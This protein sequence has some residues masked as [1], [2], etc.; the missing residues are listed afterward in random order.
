MLRDLSTSKTS[1]NLPRPEEHSEKMAIRHR[2]IVKMPSKEAAACLPSTQ[3]SFPMGPS[4]RSERKPSSQSALTSSAKQSIRE[5]SVVAQLDE[6]RKMIFYVDSFDQ[7][8]DE[9]SVIDIPWTVLQ[10][11]SLSHEQPHIICEKA[12]DADSDDLMNELMKKQQQL[13]ALENE[14]EPRLRNLLGQVV[15]ERI[16]YDSK[17]SCKIRAIRDECLDRYNKV[18]ERKK[19]AVLAWQMQQ[20][21]DMDAV[22]DICN[23]GEVSVNNQILF[24]E[25]CNVA[26]HQVC[27]GIESVPVGD[28]FCR[29]C[30]FF[31]RH[32]IRRS[33]AESEGLVAKTLSEPLPI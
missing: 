12:I 9:I 22:C 27:Y 8:G 6:A 2:M 33:R 28:W 18:M 20:E 30:R 3:T 11:F 31:N 1:L 29:V 23:D 25:S 16:R 26:V 32:E 14:L 5:K 10:S 13:M 24:C 19:A 21:Q 15:R 4:T 17:S 7:L